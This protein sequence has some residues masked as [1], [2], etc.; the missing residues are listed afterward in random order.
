MLRVVIESPLGAPTRELIERNKVYA[1]ACVVDSLRRSEAPYASHLFFDQPGILDDLAPAER[2]VG[3][4]AGFCWGKAADLVAVYVDNGLSNG[5][6]RGIARA[7]TAGQ[8]IVYRTLRSGGRDLSPEEAK[9]LYQPIS[10]FTG[11]RSPS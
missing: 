7:R 3:I 4:Q 11:D 9:D 5:M 1:K 10:S 8:P 6:V 2:E